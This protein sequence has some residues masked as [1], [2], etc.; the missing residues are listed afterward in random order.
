MRGTHFLS[1]PLG[2]VGSMPR[3]K[4]DLTVDE[5][6]V[7]PPVQRPVGHPYSDLPDGG[8][9]ACCY[10]YEELFAEK[11]R[12][13]A[14]RTRPRDLYDV[15]HLYRNHEFRPTAQA[16]MDALHHKCAF[17]KIAIPTFASLTGMTDELLGDWQA[18][19]GHQLPTL[20][21]FEGYW[22]VLPEFFRWIAGD[23]APDIPEAAPL[24][25]QETLF[26]P[27]V[28][29]LRRQGLAGSSHLEIIRFAAANH[30]CIDLGYQSHI[31]RIEPYSLRRTLAGDILLY[32]VKTASKAP[33]RRHRPS[34]QNM[35]WSSRPRRRIRFHRTHDVSTMDETSAP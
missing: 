16:V 2:R 1:G 26:R 25:H 33:V 29:A 23:G 35:P 22:D 5:V 32:A 34:C 9:A 21:P 20:P 31:R 12:A 8:I 4:L 6:L 30:L 27:A 24:T 15:V 14:E 28:G 17:K 3:I 10:A 18:M 7:L 11:V 19:L 13:L